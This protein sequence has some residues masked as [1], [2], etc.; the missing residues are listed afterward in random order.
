MSKK[1]LE[2]S[3][4]SMRFGGLL[5]VIFFVSLTAFGAAIMGTW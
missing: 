2:V 5:A 1:L 4:L 3:D